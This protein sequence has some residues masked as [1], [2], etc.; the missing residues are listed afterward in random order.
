MAAEKCTRRHPC[1]HGDRD[2]KRQSG[3]DKNGA[4]RV[5]Y[6]LP[7]IPA[8]KYCAPISVLLTVNFGLTNSW[9]AI[10]P[11]SSSYSAFAERLTPQSP[12]F[13]T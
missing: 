7:T 8:P 3:A 12:R 5:E 1:A 9:L 13:V 10:Q 4:S 11:S 2:Q 6:G